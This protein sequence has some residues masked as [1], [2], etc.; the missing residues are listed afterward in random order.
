M[1][2][3]LVVRFCRL[4]VLVLALKLRCAS[5]L[6]SATYTTKTTSCHVVSDAAWSLW[7]IFFN[8]SA[9]LLHQR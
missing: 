9:R 2:S 5:H 1:K 3:R 6:Q 4:L 8:P 7:H